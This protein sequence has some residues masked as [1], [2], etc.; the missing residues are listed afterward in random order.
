MMRGFDFARPRLM[1]D[2]R[3]IVIDVRG[4]RKDYHGLRPLRVQHLAVRAAE[5]VALLGFDQAAAEVFVNLVTAAT[6]PDAGEVRAFGQLTTAIQD[7]DTW[8]QSLDR[9]GILSERAV[10]LDNLTVEQNLTMP[11]TMSLHD[12]PDAVRSK[13]RAVA[14]EVGI[15]SAQL[16]QPVAALSPSA[17]LRLRLG[18]ALAPDPAVLLSEHPNAVLPPDELASFAADY[19]RIVSTRGIASIVLTADGAF[20]SAVASRILTLQQATGE[21]K[22]LGGWRRWFSY[23]PV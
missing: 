16:E 7:A 8:L 12:V 3:D 14:Q 2:S 22:P 23:R 11:V 5:S 19:S 4:V 18:R 6:V 13:I 21:L 17:R 1:P 10:V 20:A 9:F 15:T